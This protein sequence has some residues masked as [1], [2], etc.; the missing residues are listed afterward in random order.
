M[1]REH[2]S[3]RLSDKNRRKSQSPK[4][5]LSRF[6]CCRPGYTAARNWQIVNHGWPVD[7]TYRSE[8][9]I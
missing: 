2:D 5:G 8:S 7:M 3:F 6:D 9:D 4:T 1:I